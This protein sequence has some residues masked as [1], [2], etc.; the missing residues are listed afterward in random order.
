MPAND[1]RGL[2]D[3][4]TAE[5]AWTWIGRPS[6][7]SR[8][9]AANEA[10]PIENNLI[11]ELVRGRR[12]SRKDFLRRSA[13]FGLS[14]GT[15]GALLGAVGEAAAAAAGFRGASARPAARSASAMIAP[16]A[17]PEP[18]KLADEGGLGVASHRRAS[19]S[20][21]SD[22]N[23]QLQPWLATSWKP[24]ATATVWTFQ[25]RKGVKFHNGQTLTADDVVATFKVLAGPKLG[26]GLRVRGHP[27]AGRRRQDRPVH[28][29][30]P[31]AS[32]RRAASRTSS[33]RR[34]TRASIL[35]KNYARQLARR[36]SSSAPAR[37][38]S[39]ATRRASA[40]SSSA[41]R[42]TGAATRRS[43]ASTLTF[44]QGTAPQ[45]LA[46]KAGTLDLVQ[47]LSAQEAA[48]V[49]EQLEVPDLGRQDL[50]P[51]RDRDAHR[52]RAVQ[53]RACAPGGRADARP[54][55]A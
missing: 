24:N 26:G 18:S 4:T 42:P 11:D 47:Q 23:L 43:T 28:G 38:S 1:A 46:L 12:S 54:A 17:T 29:A 13:M 32:S 48:L 37:T 25:I 2:G 5:G 55:A 51:P 19:S 16:T 52:H 34:P 35:P 9:S 33:A 36:R 10:G 22:K 53:R 49:R 45:V 3:L 14:A 31:P 27:L 44:Y 30:V 50:E 21:F 20:T 40:P 6:G 41:T 39:R 8:S 15:V 7:R